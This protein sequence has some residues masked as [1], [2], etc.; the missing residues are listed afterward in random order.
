M[1]SSVVIVCLC[2]VI[3]ITCHGAEL[4]EQAPESFQVLFQTSVDNGAGSFVVDVT[5]SYSPWGVD[6]FYALVKANY[7]ADNYFFRV[8]PGFVVQFGLSSNPQATSN[9]D[10]SIPDDQPAQPLGNTEATITFATA[11]PNTRTTQLFINYGDNSRLDS[12]G[13]TAFGRVIKGM[14]VVNRIC[15][16]YGEKP[17]Q[18]RIKEEGSA[19]MNGKNFP[20]ID[21]IISTSLISSAPLRSNT[22]Q[23]RLAQQIS[24]QRIREMMTAAAE[25]NMNNG[26]NQEFQN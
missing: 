18:G 7:Y 10:K 2:L 9:W 23:P 16:T 21:K 20:G 19:Y 11:G 15:N 6:R 24:V 25:D 17:D 1:R 12:M 8:V 5:R 13:F 3:A 26:E 4:M 22:L 14:D